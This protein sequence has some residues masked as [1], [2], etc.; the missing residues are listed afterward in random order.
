MQCRQG[1][2]SL[3]DRQPPTALPALDRTSTRRHGTNNRPKD[4]SALRPARKSIQ[5]ERGGAAGPGPRGSLPRLRGPPTK[6][7]RQKPPFFFAER[8]RW[9]LLSQKTAF[10]QSSPYLCVNSFRDVSGHAASRSALCSSA[11]LSS[12][13]H[14][15]GKAF[16]AGLDN[17]K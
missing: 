9:F 2:R 11:I 14:A 10:R 8:K 12:L 4:R 7:R 13:W 1:A 15:S 17:R 3:R 6:L 16:Q 5:P